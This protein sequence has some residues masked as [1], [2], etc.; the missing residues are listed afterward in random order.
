MFLYFSSYIDEN[1]LSKDLSFFVNIIF[2]INNLFSFFLELIKFFLLIS[3]EI[4]FNLLS[5]YFSLRIK[6]CGGIFLSKTIFLILLSFPSC[7]LFFKFFGEFEFDL[8]FSL[9]SALKG[10][11]KSDNLL[12]FLISFFFITVLLI[13]FFNLLYLLLLLI[14][15][16]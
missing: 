5:S 11:L 15:L 9:I 1:F 7:L 2:S 6:F 8:F 10:I 14:L 3:G 12:C 13:S 16:S 4:K